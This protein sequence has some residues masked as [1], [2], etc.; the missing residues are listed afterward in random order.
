VQPV[1]MPVEEA[2]RAS[3]FAWM[4]TARSDGDSAQSPP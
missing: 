1:D 2:M 3:L 4:S